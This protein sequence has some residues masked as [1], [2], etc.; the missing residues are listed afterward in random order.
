VT[1]AVTVAILSGLVV[2]AFIWFVLVAEGGRFGCEQLIFE[3]VSA[4]GTVGL[5]TGITPELGAPSR[6]FLIALMFIGR[7][8]PLT[9]VVSVSRREK[10]DRVQYPSEPMLIG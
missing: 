8:G 10:P 5:S 7:L 6:L 3:V 1:R 4:F 2:M 9:L